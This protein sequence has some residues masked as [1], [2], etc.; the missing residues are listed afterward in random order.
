M[1]E[2]IVLVDDIIP[3]EGMRDAIIIII[4]TIS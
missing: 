3:A 4:I 1:I 2:Q